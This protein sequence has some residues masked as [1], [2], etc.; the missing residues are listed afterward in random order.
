M[1][2]QITPLL[3]PYDPKEYWEQVRKIIRE[4]LKALEAYKPSGVDFEIPGLTYKPLYKMKE[5]CVLLGVT[6]PTIYDWI[7][8]GKLKPYKIRSRVYFLWNDVQGLLRPASN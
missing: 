1:E 8:H 6:R 2:K 3:F 4:E 7:A 5:I